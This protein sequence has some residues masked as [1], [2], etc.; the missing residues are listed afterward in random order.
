MNCVRAQCQRVTPE[1]V[2]A[3]LDGINDIVC[4]H[5][6]ELKTLINQHDLLTEQSLRSKPSGA[7]CR[8]Q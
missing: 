5:I 3:L 2:A 7:R 4:N 8:V 1:E 6:V